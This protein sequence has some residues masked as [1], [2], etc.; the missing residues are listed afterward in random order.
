MVAYPFNYFYFCIN[1]LQQLRTEVFHE[2]FQ[3]I[4]NFTPTHIFVRYYVWYVHNTMIIIFFAKIAY[5]WLYINFWRVSILINSL[6]YVWSISLLFFHCCQIHFINYWFKCL[7]GLTVCVCQC[8]IQSI[9]HW[10]E[11]LFGRN[12]YVT[13]VMS[14]SSG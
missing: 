13:C 7:F 14:L 3:C 9:N 11:C 10:S 5:R 6:I 1:C 12:V 2:F 4:H 8:Q